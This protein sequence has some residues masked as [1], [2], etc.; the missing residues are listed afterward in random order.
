LN[1]GPA[2]CAEPTPPTRGLLSSRVS[3]SVDARPAQL[4]G[5]LVGCVAR[6]PLPFGCY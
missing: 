6:R 5:T 3:F 4:S 1:R 2:S